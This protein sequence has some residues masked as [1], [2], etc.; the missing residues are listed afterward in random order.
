MTLS[1]G[2]LHFDFSSATHWPYGPAT[3]VTHNLSFTAPRRGWGLSPAPIEVTRPRGRG[4][5][6]GILPPS[7]LLG[8]SMSDQAAGQQPFGFVLP[9]SSGKAIGMGKALL[10]ALTRSLPPLPGSC[11]L[12][13]W[14]HS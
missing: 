5:A 3:L 7:C 6:C 13:V 11:S 14:Y 8:N 12:L 1:R 4:V 10:Q 2:L 9:V